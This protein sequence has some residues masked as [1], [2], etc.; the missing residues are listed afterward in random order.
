MRILFSDEKNLNIDGV[1][2]LQNDRVWALSLSEANETGGIVEK[3]NF[4][5]KS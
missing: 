4:H 2:E 5:K 1:D 3:R